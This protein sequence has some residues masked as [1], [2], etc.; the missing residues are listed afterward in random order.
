MKKFK[1]PQLNGDIIIPAG[2][3]VITDACYF[4]PRNLWSNYVDR[5][6]ENSN[7]GISGVTTDEE[8]NEFIDIFTNYGDGVYDLTKK[9]KAVGDLAVDSGSL[10]I[11][12]YKVAQRWAE[13]GDRDGFKGV[14]R[15]SQVIDLEKDSRLEMSNGN[16]SFGPFA[17]IT[18]AD[19]DEGD[20]D[21]C[22]KISDWCNC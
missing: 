21:I 2:K 22:G 3:Y 9:G 10:A 11:I 18:D 12:P 4:Y 13:M 7:E 15:L 14:P 8:G 6:F 5:R 1:F 20:C 16:F 19:E 17:V